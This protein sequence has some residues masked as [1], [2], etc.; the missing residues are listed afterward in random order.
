MGPEIQKE[1]RSVKE[2]TEKSRGCTGWMAED[3]QGLTTK[4]FFTS[5][6]WRK[7][8]VARVNVNPAWECDEIWIRDMNG[9]RAKWGGVTN[10]A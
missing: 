1:R 7:N 5:F 8:I 4:E 3:F 9:R 10:A 6:S 2:G